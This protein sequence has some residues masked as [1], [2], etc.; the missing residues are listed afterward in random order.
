MKLF[1]P[2]Q[3][4]HDNTFKRKLKL[5]LLGSLISRVKLY[6]FASSNLYQRY[7]QNN[8]MLLCKHLQTNVTNHPNNDT[9]QAYTDRS[10]QDPGTM[11]AHLLIQSAWLQVYSNAALQPFHQD[12]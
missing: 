6:F 7:L 10:Y 4:G 11:L 5:L 3:V 8:P 12:V 1:C 9:F 2:R